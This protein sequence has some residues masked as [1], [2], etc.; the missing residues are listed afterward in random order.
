MNIPAQFKPFLSEAKKVLANLQV[1]AIEFSGETYQVQVFDKEQNEIWTFLQFDKKGMLK[2]A[3]CSS[4]EDMDSAACVHLA[5]AYLRIFNGHSLPIHQRFKNSLWNQLFTLYANRMGYKRSVLHKGREPNSYFCSSASG[6]IIFFIRAKTEDAGQKLEE[7]INQNFEET[8]ET[9]LK[10]SNLPQEEIIL[11]REGRPSPQL[12]YELSFWNDLAKWVML[13]QDA[14]EEY[15][16]D[17]SYSSSGL[18][19]FL[20]ADFPQI[21]V[22]FYLS[23]AN[24][25]LIIPSLATVKSPLKV[26]NT[27]QDAIE[28]IVYDKEKG[29]LNIIPKQHYLKE[30]RQPS[31]KP[32]YKLDGWLYLPK[33]GFYALDQ[34]GLLSHPVVC[35]EDI[36]TVLNQHNAIVKNLLENATVYETPIQPSY[37]L[38]FDPNWNLHI[39]TYIFEP[40]DLHTPYSR[41][42]GQWVYLEDEGFFRLENK[43]FDEINLVVPVDQVSDFVNSN[44][45]WLN[46]QEGFHTH[47]TNIEAQ[48]TYSLSPDRRLSFTR[49]ISIED[50]STESKDFGSWVYVKG[51]GFY[52]KIS[53]HIGLPV[54]PGIQLSPDQIP[55]FI[56]M[57]RD[58]LQLVPGFF[59]ATCPVTKS[60]VRIELLD[61]EIIKI[62]PE[63]ELLPEYMDANLTFFDDFVY[64]PNE[65]FHEL[66][67]DF[68]LPEIFRQTLELAPENHN[69]FL[70][71]DYKELQKFAT[72]IDE[73][74]IPPQEIVLA[75][76]SI[77]KQTGEEAGWYTLKLKYKTDIGEVPLYKIWNGVKQ[78]KK[79]LFTEGGLIDL[80][81]ER[82]NWLRSIRKD[83]WEKKN[84][85]LSL[86]TLELIRLNAFEEIV[87]M[88]PEKGDLTTLDNY[89]KTKAALQELLTFG[90]PEEP[91]ISNLKSSLRPYQVIGL[92]WLWF[93]YQHS[94]SGLL[95][96]DMGLGKTHQAMA[97]L[98]AVRNNIRKHFGEKLPEV[99]FLVV[100][101]TSVIY[102]WQE[103]LKKFMPGVR[104]CT[105]YGLN[106]SLDDFH[107][108]YDVLLTTYG[109][110]RNE[111]ELLSKVPFEVA[112]FDEIQ[113]AKNHNS[114]VHASLLMANA[115]M[116]LGLTGTPIENHL[117]ELKSLFDIVLPTYMPG[118]SDYREFFVKPIEKELNERKK[119]LLTR[120]I[121]PFV[122][123][124][125]K[126]DVLLD[127]PAKTEEIA[128]CELMEE[129]QKLYM[130]VLTQSRDQI[131]QEM[132]DEGAPIPYIHIFALLSSLKQICDHPAVYLKRP[133]IY[134]DFK[135]GKWN[136]F[137]ELLNEARQS[138][139]KVVVFSQYLTMLDII[140][141]HLQEN[142]IEYASIR[143]ATINRGEELQRFNTDPNCEVFV[144]SLQATGMGV[145][146]TAGS[147]VIHYDRW[148]NA[149]RENQAT[150]RVHRI[151]Q[152]R[153][154]QVFKLV[155]M[156]TFEEKIDEIISRKAFLMEEV[157]RVDDHQV[158]KQFNRSEIMEL[159]QYVGKG[160]NHKL[161][162]L[163]DSE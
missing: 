30:K 40:D 124:R 102:H 77:S 143:G 148:W 18:P 45:A 67:I 162:W 36:V 123:R 49:K 72:H 48:L 97:L 69:L 83:R 78:K 109:I 47:L 86:N 17:F 75:A 119:S 82:F 133:D 159:L 126:Q 55:L 117:R 116:R 142:G 100:C 98:A 79:H 144:G 99:H 46:T 60:G 38:Y 153:G 158:I 12:A 32:G 113:V 121:K 31:K 58:E 125:K 20:E 7:I 128:H 93:L 147:V 25:P 43:Q 137:V 14:K 3:F 59:S 111:C 115:K 132:S 64:T 74:L 68:R 106:R 80:E 76:D 135:S 71:Y 103:K 107:S 163:P 120:F 89:E 16:I 130:Q 81:E 104:V 127:L 156:D 9:S 94:L 145:D 151:G 157:V 88:A 108:Q 41:S 29:C 35:Q 122:L 26:Y 62:T 21:E 6:K 66:P 50:E 140:E 8:E 90:I 15:K 51:Q 114:R 27:S 112:I 2:D 105:F 150:D 22:C 24:L 39:S 1:G 53:S 11:W 91:D 160:D 37:K 28:K 136:L 63:Y 23:E 87:V 54:R 96:D 85:I 4:E 134:K 146:L 101:P 61:K 161:V 154:V 5:A 56:R 92:K 65:G 13:T 118:E 44:R 33:E 110:W 95:C 138:R 19:N 10:F 52:S 139:Q 84:N 155:T 70:E 73:R 57:N 129:Q 149:A 34:H 152:T 42:L 131:M 141:S